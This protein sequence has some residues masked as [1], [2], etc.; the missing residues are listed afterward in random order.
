MQLKM[1][2]TRRPD[3]PRGEVVMGGVPIGPPVVRATPSDWGYKTSPMD[4][5]LEGQTK[6]RI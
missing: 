4:R 3:L 5:P 6:N 1:N 2:H